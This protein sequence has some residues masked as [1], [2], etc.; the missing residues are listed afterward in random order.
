MNR[1]LIIGKRGGILNWY[2]DVLA[3]ADNMSRGFAL[4][5]ENWRS[6]AL[7]GLLGDSAP[8]YRRQVAKDLEGVLT[9]FSPT[10]ILLVDLFYLRSEINELLTQSGAKTAQWIGDRFEKRLVENT[11]IH[12]FY[13][14]DTALV[15]QGLSL[16]L[17]SKYLP[18]ATIPSQATQPS[19]ESRR[20]EL[21][22]VAAPSENRIELLEKINYPTLVI[23]PKWPILKNPA[24]KTL[25]KRLSLQAVRE[26]YGNHKFILNQINTNNIM[27]GLPTRCFD[28]T[29][30]G[31]CLVTDAVDDLKL[32]FTV[33]RDIVVYRNPS[34]I[35]MLIQNSEH[36][37]AIAANGHAHCIKNH[38]F[39]HRLKTLM[40][41]M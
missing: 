24:I 31:S 12:T 40:D 18:L 41:H 8:A 33:D 17:S 7:K 15:R 35:A 14:T 4:N 20:S 6:H 39:I 38:S 22:F 21:L 34:E 30:Y 3:S 16:G 10:H 23:G 32:N 36:C 11:S 29:A 27:A 5:H 1:L 26:L 25:N 13:F 2:E 28:A 19:W 37:R 9:S